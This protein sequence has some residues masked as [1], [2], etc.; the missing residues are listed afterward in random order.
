MGTPGG[1]D[2]ARRGDE[3]VITHHGKRAATLRGD[4]AVRFLADVEGGDPQQVMA[5][6]T[7]NYRRGNERDARRHPRNR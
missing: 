4:A 2:Y 5:R 3:V 6:A 1:F 7:G